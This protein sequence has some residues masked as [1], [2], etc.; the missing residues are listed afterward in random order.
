MSTATTTTAPRRASTAPARPTRTR[1]RPE[2]SPRLRVVPPPHPVPRRAPFVAVVLTL[3]VLGLGALLVLNTVLAQGSFRVEDLQRQ[4]AVLA[5]DEQALQQQ[6][7][8]LAAPGR[9]SHQARM[10]GMVPLSTPAFL[11]TSDGKVL[12]HA[13]P[14]TGLVPQWARPIV[15]P[16]PAP[17]AAAAPEPEKKATDERQPPADASGTGAARQPRDGAEAQQTGPSNGGDNS[18]AGGDG[19][20]QR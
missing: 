8:E 1:Q 13:A 11:R 9:L 2:S 17:P 20:G 7:A 4:V 5:D 3:L 16:R 18:S 19:G 10:L 15:H 14:A 6:V 12:G